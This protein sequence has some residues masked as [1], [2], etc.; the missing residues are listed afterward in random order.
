MIS[1]HLF[2]IM[3]SSAELN[4]HCIVIQ[5][6]TLHWETRLKIA[7]Q[8]RQK[9]YTAYSVLLRFHQSSNFP[10]A[11]SSVK[12]QYSYIQLSC[13]RSHSFYPCFTVWPQT[14]SLSK[15]LKVCQAVMHYPWCWQ[16]PFHDSVTYQETVCIIF[17]KSL[18]SCN[19]KEIFLLELAFFSL[20]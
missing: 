5:P 1:G 4:R 17:C 15:V 11:D 14:R 20:V 8:C 10:L 7:L 9:D 2:Y 18:C 3:P 19:L 16:L 13:Q 6:Y 12:T